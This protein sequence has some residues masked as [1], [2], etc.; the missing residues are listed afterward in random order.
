MPCSSLLTALTAGSGRR[1][2]R[3]RRSAGG[4]RSTRGRR[5]ATR[6]R[7]AD[8][9]RIRHIDTGR[10]I[11]APG[12]R[13]GDPDYGRFLATL[14]ALNGDVHLAD[15]IALGFGPQHQYLHHGLSLCRAV[16]SNTGKLRR[17]RLRLP[18]AV[19]EP[20]DDGT[21]TRCARLR[22]VPV[23]ELYCGGRA[24]RRRARGAECPPSVHVGWL[25]VGRVIE[26]LLGSLDLDAICAVEWDGRP[27]RG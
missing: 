26:R 6:L 14:V 13:G 3:R 15:Q 17:F 19:G 24:I 7:S 18:L 2:W 4:S 20:H 11:T 10:R 21:T 12:S 16:W 9:Y 1:G 25:R 8:R 22:V 5:R 23:V 27:G